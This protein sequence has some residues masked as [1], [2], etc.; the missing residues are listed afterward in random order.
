M[1]RGGGYVVAQEPASGAWRH[2]LCGWCAH[3]GPPASGWFASCADAHSVPVFLPARDQAL[4]FDE[5]TARQFAARL[6]DRYR[7]VV[8]HDVEELP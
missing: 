3:G 7:R 6:D 5:E 1:T 2:Y 8:R 4:V